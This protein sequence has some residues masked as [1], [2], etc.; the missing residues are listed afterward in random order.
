[1]FDPK[2]K[3]YWALTNVVVPDATEQ[4]S[5]AGSIRNTVALMRSTDLR[6]WEMKCILL[7]HPVCKPPGFLRSIRKSRRL[8]RRYFRF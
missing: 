8:V 4:E 5:N 6:I 3:A 1:M 7:Y 2:S